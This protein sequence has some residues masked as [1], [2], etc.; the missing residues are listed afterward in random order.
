MRIA[1]KELEKCLG[2]GWK[3]PVI[4]HKNAVLDK[5]RTGVVPI[6]DRKWKGMAAVDKHEV[7]RRWV[8][9]R[10]HVL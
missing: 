7:Q 2:D 3:L 8:K 4:D 1:V 9:T 5:A 6:D 10:Q